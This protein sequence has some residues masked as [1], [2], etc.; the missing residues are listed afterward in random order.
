MLGVIGWGF[1]AIDRLTDAEGAQKAPRV[2]GRASGHESGWKKGMRDW[3]S[4]SL[5]AKGGPEQ[6]RAESVA[7]NLGS[8]EIPLVADP[9]GLKMDSLQQAGPE[10]REPVAGAEK[11]GREVPV[12]LYRLNP[13][14]QPVLAQVRR[15]LAE[16]DADLA[17]R[18]ALVIRGPSAAETEKDYIDSFIRKPRILGASVHDGCAVI[19]FDT[20]FGAG[21]SYQTLKFQIRQLFRNAQAWTGAPCLELT[22]RGKYQPHLGTDGIYFPRRLDAEWLAENL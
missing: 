17:H 1:F 21:V 7:R 13:R 14:G 9:Q 19:D 4:R 3:L 5:A 18:L 10:G 16:A 22:V 2:Q 12:F 11:A 20:H 6:G 15:R 8:S